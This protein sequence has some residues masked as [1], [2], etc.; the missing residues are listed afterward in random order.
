MAECGKSIVDY[1][2]RVPD[3]PI[4]DKAAELELLEA[5]EFDVAADG[6]PG[7]DRRHHKDGLGAT[8][9]VICTSE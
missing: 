1:L 5:E 3:R 7:A 8:E 4:R 2:V 9:L 6:L